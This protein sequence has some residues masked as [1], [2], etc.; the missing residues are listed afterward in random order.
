MET[1][2][3]DFLVFNGKKLL[4]ENPSSKEQDGLNSEEQNKKPTE[5]V[6]H[7]L[8]KKSSCTKYTFGAT[9]FTEKAYCKKMPKRTLTETGQ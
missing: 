6:Y 2:F 4:R 1:Q 5:T 3:K 9:F 8:V 7:I